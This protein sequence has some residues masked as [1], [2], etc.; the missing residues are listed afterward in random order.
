LPVVNWPVIRTEP[1][2]P[3]PGYGES[4]AAKSPGD[5]PLPLEVEENI[6][7]GALPVPETPTASY[8]KTVP[9]P[10]AEIRDNEETGGSDREVI[11]PVRENEPRDSSETG[12]RELT[13]SSSSGGREPEGPAVETRE[14]TPRNY[15]TLT[16]SIA[17]LLG[18]VLV[19]TAL[20]ILFVPL[21]QAPDIAPVPTIIP[22]V[23][24]NSTPT[25][26]PVVI[27]DAGVWIHIIY[28]GSFYG[29]VG[30]PSEISDIAG[31][32]NQFH[33][34]R[35]SGS[36][37]QGD[38]RKQDNSGDTL[39]VEVLNNGTRVYSSSVRAP[40]GTIHFLIDTETGKPPASQS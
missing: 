28:P 34:I 23:T 15:Q 1:A 31:T 13:R 6:H 29:R 35:N 7:T 5:P 32:G 12:P 18:I 8:G 20:G 36:L 33:F 38:I 16:I 17:V 19:I 3:D 9:V 37:L 40:M 27:P 25:V 22:P 26:K 21:H 30:N 24:Q 4:D 2:I 39:T 14:R 11:P 10:G